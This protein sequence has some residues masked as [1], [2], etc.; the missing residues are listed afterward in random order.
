MAAAT[1]FASG[2]ADLVVAHGGQGA[3]T[4]MAMAAVANGIVVV[5]GTNEDIASAHATTI[6]VT[7]GATMGTT[8]SVC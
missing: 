5:V 8:I 4:T 7:L 1:V 2:M 3:S 6:D